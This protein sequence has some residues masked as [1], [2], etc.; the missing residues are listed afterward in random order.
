MTW[1]DN[2]P[3][4]WGVYEEDEEEGGA[5]PPQQHGQIPLPPPGS[6]P[7]KQPS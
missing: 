6:P 3:I 4:G 2:E 5:G 1:N 7:G